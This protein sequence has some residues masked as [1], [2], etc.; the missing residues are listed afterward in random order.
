ME[1]APHM[2]VTNIVNLV[3]QEERELASLSIYASNLI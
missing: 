1:Q 3:G 2:Y